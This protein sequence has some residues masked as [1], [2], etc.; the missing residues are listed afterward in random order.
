VNRKI[1]IQS[2][3]SLP[4]DLAAELGIFPEFTDGAGYDVNLRTEDRKEE[5]TVR[6][7]EGEHAPHVL[8]RGTGDGFLFD[9]VVGRVIWALSA[10]SDNLQVDRHGEEPNQSP[11]RNAGSRPSS[12]DSPA[13]KTPSSLGPRG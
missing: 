3:F 1:S 9:R 11:Q 8:V 10:H 12:S 2:Y 13:S 5:V 7:V 6:F 4:T